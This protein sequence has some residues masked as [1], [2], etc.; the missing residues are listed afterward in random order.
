MVGIMTH[1]FFG[2]TFTQTYFISG[3]VENI[4]SFE[5]RWGGGCEKFPDVYQKNARY[6]SRGLK[7]AVCT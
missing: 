6:Q 5:L 7:K 2:L 3:E 4:T 1:F